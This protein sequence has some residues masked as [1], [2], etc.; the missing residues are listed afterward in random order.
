[1]LVLAYWSGQTRP[2][3]L[4]MAESECCTNPVYAAV[5]RTAS[6]QLQLH[7]LNSKLVSQRLHASDGQSV[8]TSRTCSLC[9]AV[10]VLHKPCACSNS[11]T[12]SRQQ[13][14]ATEQFQPHI[15]HSL[16]HLFVCVG[17]VKQ[18]LQPVASFTAVVWAA[19]TLCMQQPQQQPAD[20]RIQKSLQLHSL[21]SVCAHAHA[22]LQVPPCLCIGP[23]ELAASTCLIYVRHKP[24]AC[25]STQNR[26]ARSSICT[27]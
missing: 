5:I 18:I 12:A 20:S 13:R 17:S 26:T 27:V 16:V 14:A 11:T 19:Q 15:M 21:S 22:K 7:D 24:C 8:R 10:S 3:S 2:C 4:Y 25:S 1:M 9:Q 6:K 23:A